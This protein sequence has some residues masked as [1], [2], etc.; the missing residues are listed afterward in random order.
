MKTFSKSKISVALLGLLASSIQPALAYDMDV[1]YYVTSMILANLGGGK[2]LNA[3]QLMA[4][5]ADQYVDENPITLPSLNPLK[6]YQRWNWH[7]PAASYTATYGATKRNSYFAQFNVKNGLKDNDPVL[8]GMALHTFMD[9]YSHEGWE[10]Y[11]G[12]AKAGH[13]P[14]RPHLD[15]DKFREMVNSVYAILTEWY[16]KNAWGDGTNIL[17]P[18]E[19]QQWAKY[20]PPAYNDFKADY[21]LGEIT[22]RALTWRLH[23]QEKFPQAKVLEY[24]PLTGQ[25]RIDFERVADTY[26]I[27]TKCYGDTCGSQ[28][29][30]ANELAYG[31]SNATPRAA[32]ALARSYNDLAVPKLARL[33]LAEPDTF[34]FGIPAKLNTQL[35]MQKLLREADKTPDGWMVLNGLIGGPHTSGWDMT[36]YAN[37]LKRHLGSSNKTKR[38]IVAGI[39]NGIDNLDA[40]SCGQVNSIFKNTKIKALKAPERAAFLASLSPNTH[41]IASCTPATLE[42]LNDFLDDADFGGLAAAR[43]YLVV[44]DE[45]READYSGAALTVGNLRGIRAQ[46]EKMISDQLQ[47]RNVTTGNAPALPQAIFD[48]QRYWAGRANEDGDD[49]VANSASDQA[50]LADLAT[51]LQSAMTN[52]EVEMVSGLASTIATYGPEDN[53]GSALIASLQTALSDDRFVDIRMVIGYALQQLTGTTHDLSVYWN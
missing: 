49:A 7:F 3:Q 24:Q 38:F 37:L 48:E 4:A 39:I 36:P 53:P 25:P 8:L 15:I 32:K 16:K 26:H 9:S 41:T 2:P 45:D 33:V 43:L 31:A 1:H 47:A 35:G 13:D 20:I 40:K 11:F 14:D 51:A 17:S 10:A 42:V 21:E 34:R 46:A 5:V 22:E 18:D 28:T 27:P 44:S 23:I 6:S 30:R 29:V 12:H 19:Y 50:H 52:G